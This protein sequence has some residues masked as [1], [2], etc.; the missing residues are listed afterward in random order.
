[1]D[2]KT[3]ITKYD[4][5]S[6]KNRRE[7]KL[8]RWTSWISAWSVL[9]GLM[10]LYWLFGGNGYPFKREEGMELFAGM[11]TY[12]PAQ[13]GGSIFVVLCLIGLLVGILMRKPVTKILIKR[14]VLIYAWGLAAVLLL[15]VPDSSLIAALA[16]AFLFKFQFSWPMF[17]QMICIIG[18]VSWGL[19]AVAYQ[20]KIRHACESCGREENGKPHFLKRWSRWITYLAALAPVPYAITRY[21]WAMGIPFGVEASFFEDFST[22]NPNHQITEWVFGSLCIAG[23]ILTLGL[24]QKWGETFPRWIP[25][26]H[27]KRVPILLAVIPAIT[28][29]IAVTSAGFVFTTSFIAV[30]LQIVPVD[31]NL[32]LNGIWGTMGPMLLWVPWGVALGLAA[33]AYYYRRRGRCHDCGRGEIENGSK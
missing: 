1:M 3:S 23:G 27:G 4:A 5:S 18:A 15:F 28:V 30:Q 8:R 17:N 20:R 25:F 10:H 26:I 14:L 13:V 7:M 33:I 6:L 2:S 19:A 21:A 12:L 9:Y 16:Y 11:V 31:D 24:I 29:A 32:L 22:L